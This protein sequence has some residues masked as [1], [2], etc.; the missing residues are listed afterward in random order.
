[1]SEI[2]SDYEPKERY[3]NN[4][5]WCDNLYISG[6]QYYK[7]VFTFLLF[8]APSGLMLA[9]LIKI[10]NDYS[11][12]GPIVVVL[13]LYVIAV[14]ATF[15]GG[16]TDPGIL[17]RQNENFFY[18]TKRP[19]LRQVI[20]GHLIQLNYCYTCSL[21]RP[22]RTSHCA[23]CD[24]CVE[25]FDH[26]CLWLATCVGKRNYKFFYLL[27]FILNLS[28]LFQMGYSGYL[29]WYQCKSAKAKDKYDKLVFIGLSILM[30]FD[31][32]FVIFFIGKLF[33]LHTWLL[34]KNLTF[35]EH[36]KEKWKKAPGVNPF[37]K[38]ACYV[39]KRF[40]F[41]C[42]PKTTLII[43]GE[44]KKAHEHCSSVNQHLRIESNKINE[45]I[46]YNSERDQIK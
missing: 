18:T 26:H 8:S 10:N 34:F 14:F 2:D 33:L 4:K 3:G 30:F 23:I 15:R 25:R 13:V 41:Y 27:I 44:Q 37:F 20:N 21:F 24:N 22:P 35:Y 7:I 19:I 42:A 17:T 46:R 11:S 5:V 40:I 39:W 43:F 9:I 29:I 32:M 1:M 36:V 28:A 45:I 38:Y 6:D 31:L 16:F 12:V